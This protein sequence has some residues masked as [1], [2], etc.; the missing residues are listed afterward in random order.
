[1]RPPFLFSSTSQTV[2]DFS[3]SN[4]SIIFIIKEG[5][6]RGRK[7]LNTKKHQNMSISILI[8]IANCMKQFP[9]F[10]LYNDILLCKYR[11]TRWQEHL[12]E[13][14]KYSPWPRHFLHLKQLKTK[15]VFSIMQLELQKN[16]ANC[17]DT[18]CSHPL[19]LTRQ[20]CITAR[21]F[22]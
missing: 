17:K 20:K 16:V 11:M 7:S 12:L 10:S 8:I 5:E 22:H 18:D 3:C 13:F 4:L 15:F 9:C 1:M 6:M 2:T 14:C 19:P 21:P